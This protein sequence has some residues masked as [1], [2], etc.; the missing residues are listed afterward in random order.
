MNQSENIMQINCA[1]DIIFED[2]DCQ[3]DTVD[4]NFGGQ[5]KEN[6][7]Q[8]LEIISTP[9]IEYIFN[10][11]EKTISFI[12]DGNS[13]LDTVNVSM[14]YVYMNISTAFNY[15]SE[16]EFWETSYQE[17]YYPFIFGQKINFKVKVTVPDS[18]IVIGNYTSLRTHKN[19]S[20]T[21][22]RFATKS[23]VVS[24]SLILGLLPIDDYKNFSKTV[25]DFRIN[26][27][28]LKSIKIPENRI[29]ELENLTVASISFFS[30]VF[31]D[32]YRNYLTG[33]DLSFVFHKNPYSN[34]NNGSFIIASQEKFATKPHI[35]PMVHEI[36]HRWLGEWTLLIEN[37]KPGAYFIKESLNE[38]MTLLFAKHY[39]GDFF[40]D[41]L[42]Q[43]EYISAYQNIK[44][45]S[46]DTSLYSMEYNNN[47]TIVYRKGIIIIHKIVE[48]MGED[49]WL[50][51]INNFYSKYKYDPELDY[52]KFLCLLSQIDVQAAELLDCYVK[53]NK[54]I[55]VCY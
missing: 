18:I 39:F 30:K 20:S 13:A 53:C 34:R 10:A 42:L 55:D 29:I 46:K 47:N 23:P 32:D 24:H 38:Y 21:I 27:Y 9:D 6:A 5:L 48:K 37:G 36:G 16:N 17:F 14:N 50:E 26:Y 35:L 4:M 31:D 19:D 45:T 41:S 12:M 8:D 28:V 22:Y 11:E 7:I 49:Q 15:R 2:K 33:K 51:F 43:K 40:Y 54:S 52:Q 3:P 25:D 44:G 1:F